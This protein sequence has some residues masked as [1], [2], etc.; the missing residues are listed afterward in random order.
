VNDVFRVSAFTHEPLVALRLFRHRGYPSLDV[1]LHVDQELAQL[2]V[3][4]ARVIGYERAGAASRYGWMA[5]DWL[6]GT[7]CDI[8]LQRKYLA[9]VEFATQLGAILAVT[10]SRRY[11]S[12]GSPPH[13]THARTREYLVHL[14]ERSPMP[15]R[16]STR[17]KRQLDSISEWAATVPDTAPVLTHGDITLT[18]AIVANGNVT[19][20]DWDNATAAPSARDATIMRRLG[21]EACRAFVAAHGRCCDSE[22]D[23]PVHEVLFLIDLLRAACAAQSTERDR[24]CV[25]Q[26]VSRTVL[27]LRK[28]GG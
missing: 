7:R 12:F 15:E 22:F 13:G 3:R 26:Q 5:V 25:E 27:A 24:V 1:L 28:V 4:R 19:L 9:P 23:A 20:I 14:L 10:H 2:G 17:T 11:L 16:L 8:A 6:P 21:M 18:N